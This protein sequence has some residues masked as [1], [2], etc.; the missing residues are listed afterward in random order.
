MIHQM[1]QKHRRFLG[2]SLIALI[3]IA[4]L[5]ALPTGYEDALLYQGTIRAV[6]K[7]VQVD[8]STIKSSGLIQSGEQMCTLLIEDGPLSGREVES[9]NFLSG[10]LEKDKIFVPGDRA[11]VTISESNGQILSAVITDHYR[12]S[13]ELWLFAAFALFLVL[14]AGKNGLQSLYSFAITVLMIWKVLVPAYLKGNEPRL[15]RHGHH[16]TADG[17][18]Y[19]VCLWV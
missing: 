10:S 12:L 5:I 9:V 11:Y 18:Y 1:I 15:G 4:I 16:C 19:S 13:A 2:T 14:F 17:H 6:G 7:V 8:N 3:I